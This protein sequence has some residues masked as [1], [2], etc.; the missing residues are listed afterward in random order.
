M[1]ESMILEKAWERFY[2]SFVHGKRYYCFKLG[3]LSYKKID[4]LYDNLVE[5]LRNQGIEVETGVKLEKSHYRNGRSF[6]VAAQYFQSENKIVFRSKNPDFGDLVHEFV[7]A[8]DKT[9]GARGNRELVANAVEYLVFCE[10][11][12]LCSPNAYRK[13]PK[14]FGPIMNDLDYL[15]DR[16][17]DIFYQ[18]DV[19]M[20]EQLKA[21][22]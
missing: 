21:A 1:S 7:H 13:Y 10:Y 15:K 8:L 4:N 11:V 9:S 3:H 2:K 19:L 20:Q 18:I 22:Q 17:F 12:G 5:V 16:I 14:K 6:S